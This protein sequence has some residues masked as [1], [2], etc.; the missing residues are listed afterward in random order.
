MI[1]KLFSFILFPFLILSN[2]QAQTNPNF[3]SE[4]DLVNKEL[5]NHLYGNCSSVGYECLENF[6]IKD[7]LYI[8]ATIFCNTYNNQNPEYWYK[9]ALNNIKELSIMPYM[10]DYLS[11]ANPVFSLWEI[12]MTGNNVTRDWNMVVRTFPGYGGNSDAFKQMYQGG[13]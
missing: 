9:L 1:K 11:G 10:M 8:T 5:L 3:T 4:Y 6:T 2:V 13:E 12:F 7:T